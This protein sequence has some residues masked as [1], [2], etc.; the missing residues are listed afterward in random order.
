MPETVTINNNSSRCFDIFSICC[1]PE[2]YGTEMVVHI[3]KILNKCKN[4]NGTIASCIALEALRYLCI[5]GIV[6]IATAWNNLE[7][8]LSGEERVPVIQGYTPLNRFVIASKLFSV[9]AD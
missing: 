4:E 8:A 9:C 1:S 2:V 3:S 6:D 7:Q 5:G